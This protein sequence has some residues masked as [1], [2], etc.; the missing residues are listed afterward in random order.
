MDTKKDNTKIEN[1]KP[2]KAPNEQVGFYF[3][4]HIKIFDPVT[5]EVLV[6]QR[7]DD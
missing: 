3:S 5:K 6:K 1:K 7:A 4:S 2:E